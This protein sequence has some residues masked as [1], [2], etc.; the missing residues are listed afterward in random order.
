MVRS[1]VGMPCL[2]GRALWRLGQLFVI[3]QRH[4]SAKLDQDGLH[5]EIPLPLR[6][7]WELGCIDLIAV[8]AGHLMVQD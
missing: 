1:L 5:G 7:A 3:G 8:S 6:E 2:E 4:V